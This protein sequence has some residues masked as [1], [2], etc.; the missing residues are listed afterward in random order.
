MNDST[1]VEIIPQATLP[2][3]NPYLFGYENCVPGHAPNPWKHPYWLMHY[4]VS[5]QGTFMRDGFCHTLRT[6]EAFTI[7]PY[8]LASYHADKDD[9]WSYIWIGFTA[10]PSLSVSLP[11][12]LN[13][14]ALGR[15][16]N[17]M[18]RAMDMTTGR[19]AFLAACLWEIMA[20]VQELE[21][22]NTDYVQKAINYMQHNY[23]NSIS[24]QNVADHL[25]L[26]RRYFSSLFRN[27][28]GSSPQ[29]Y[30]ISLR[31]RNAAILML[32]MGYSPTEAAPAV[33]YSDIY[34]FSRMFK[35]HYG[36]SPRSYVNSR[37][38][39]V[40]ELPEDSPADSTEA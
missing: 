2:A 31:L 11:P 36:L 5:G 3:L 12:V 34:N 39:H 29:E 18:K 33:G 14:P 25:N 28:T 15:I 4:V 24:I 19:N 30:L 35:R 10:A 23:R 21:Y 8:E 37:Y 32:E 16:F 13:C 40:S 7:P 38:P 22:Q 26:D 6:G 17:Q 27:K 20:T 1:M 9:P